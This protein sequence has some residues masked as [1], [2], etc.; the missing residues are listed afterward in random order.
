[1]PSSPDPAALT[2]DDRTREVSQLFALGLLRLRRPIKFSV[3]DALSARQKVSE[4]SRNEL[5]SSP[6]QSVTVHAG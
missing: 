6:E 4:N 2:P 1:M 5:A 3:P